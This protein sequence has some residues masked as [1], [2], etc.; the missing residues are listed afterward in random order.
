MGKVYETI[1]NLCQER[2]ISSAEMCRGAGIGLN[3]MTELK[4]GRHKGL[5]ADKANKIAAYFGVTVG[6]LLGEEEN[7]AQPQKQLS[8]AKQDFINEIMD[9]PDEQIKA[10][11]EA[12]RAFKAMYQK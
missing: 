4:S 3:T 6:Y 10:L 5:S 11:T 8:K 12:A 7:N 2:K 9:W 1:Y